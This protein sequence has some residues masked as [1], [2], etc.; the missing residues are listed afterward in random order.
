MPFKHPCTAHAFFPERLS[1]H[2]QG[3][4]HTVSEICINFVSHSLSDPL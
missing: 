4:C 3:L 1:N 2:R